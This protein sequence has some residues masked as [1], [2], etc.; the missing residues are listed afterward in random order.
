MVAAYRTGASLREVAKDFKETKS[1]VGRWVAHAQGKRL[2]RIDFYDKPSGSKQPKNKS[3]RTLETRVLQLR[4]YLKDKSILGLHGAA[5]I[6]E[7]MKRRGDT[8]IPAKSTISNILK[9]NGMIDN[10]TRI[11][12]PAPPPGW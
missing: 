10:R 2:D 8:T 6:L 1:T 7:E 11:R 9:R 5:T 3:P 4:K 12:R